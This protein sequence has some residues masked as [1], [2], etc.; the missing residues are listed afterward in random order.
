MR[1][2]LVNWREWGADAFAEAA[3]QAKLVL[4]DISAVW[5]H[6]CH[7]MDDTSYSDP[8]VSALINERFV[9]V[10]VDTDRMPDV[11]ERYNMGGWPT[12][13]VL[14]PTGEVLLGATYVPPDKL[15][16]TLTGLDQFYKENK[17]TVGARI[18]ELKAKKEGEL[19]ALKA[20]PSSDVTSNIVSYVLEELDRN[21]DPI[22]GGFGAEPKFP[23]PDA[24]ELLLTS[25]R[26]TGRAQY[27]DMA[28]KTLV[29]MDSYGM[30]DHV[31]GGFF[32][33]SVT[34][35]WSVPHYEKMLDVNAGLIVNYINAYRVTGNGRFKDTAM[36]TLGYVDAWLWADGGYFCGSQDADE[37][38]YKLSLEERGNKARPSVD[39]TMFTNLNA[40][41]VDA[42]LTAWEVTGE[43]GYK[44]KALSALGF[45]LNNMKGDSGGFYH[46]YDGSP[47]R[48]GLLTDQ[49]AMLKALL[50][51]YLI[52][53]DAKMFDEAFGLL[54]FMEATHWDKEIGGFY[55][56]PED[57]APVSALAFR[58]KPMAEN[59]EMARS[60]KA[61]HALTG[62]AGYLDMA[63]GCLAQHAREYREYGFMAAG[64]ALAV[65]Y[66]LKPVFEVTVVGS[67]GGADT[68]ALARAARAVLIPRG[69]VR[70]LDPDR[71][72]EEIGRK[73]LQ[74]A[75]RAAAYICTGSVCTAR[76]EE[77][78]AL[79]VKLSEADVHAP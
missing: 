9:P 70:V 11:N 46:Y 42:Y 38:Y 71:D 23:A 43:D 73:G 61:L 8:E 77:P 50:H 30:Y 2:G 16:E 33:Y 32:R 15:I 53:G 26:D 72:F 41:M 36:R 21:Y 51:A 48:F 60:L 40:R 20:P 58:V 1:G 45:I 17:D 7:V 44:E 5:C 57:P 76:V 34:R 12:T 27:L 35:D 52:T 62:E 3:G 75:S 68:E 31:M 59:S 24:V 79:R 13:A 6:W 67:S 55:D 28:E 18:A 10:R 37:E 54:A 56:L 74:A 22:H 64:Y 65:D 69:I 63:K 19:S 25:Y 47:R 66:Y 49:S 14:T 78:E 39:V 29:G 4:L